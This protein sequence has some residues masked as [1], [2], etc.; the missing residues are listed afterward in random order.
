MKKVVMA[1]SG[2]KDS[3]LA[4]YKILKKKEY[5][6]SVLLT[7][8][9]GDYDRISMHGVRKT[10]LET[11][12]DSLGIPLNI[13]TIPK[14]TANKEYEQRMR[15]ANE[16]YA[17]DGITSAVFGDIH[18]E[19][20]RKYRERNLSKAGMTAIFPLWKKSTRKLTRNFIDLG[21]KAVVTCIDSE[22]LNKEFCGKEFND[23]FLSELPRTVDPC[24]ENG[25]FHSFVYD[26]PIFRKRIRFRKG[27]II[28]RDKR[29]WFCDL[30]PKL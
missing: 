9:T 23:E 10:L 22:A 15:E 30:L 1:W 24:G 12:A 6:V 18:L 19:D 13:V 20:V 3:S 25:E 26:G 16:G 17:R 29:F 7:T 11:Q 4:L 2:G 14:K 27:E 28:L 8:V 5:K 21:F